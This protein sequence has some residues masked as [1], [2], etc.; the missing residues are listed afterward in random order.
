MRKLP[1]ELKAILAEVDQEIAPRLREI[2]DQVVYNQGKVLKAFVDH[3]VAEADL[4][5]T[6]GYGMTI[7]AE[8]SW[9]LSMPRFSI[10]KTPWCGL[11]SFPAP[12]PWQW[13]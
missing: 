3:Q 8:T 4:K 12:T 5:G 1:E 2:D 6:N 9:K 11:S 13:R 7:S 10:L